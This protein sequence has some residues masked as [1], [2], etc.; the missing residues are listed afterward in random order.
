[1]AQGLLPPA[2]EEIDAAQGPQV[3]VGRHRIEP[4]RSV[5]LFLCAVEVGVVDKR[6]GKVGQH[7]G[8]VG[9]EVGRHRHVGE[10]QVEVPVEQGDAPE[11]TIGRAVI[12]VDRHGALGVELGLVEQRPV[13]AGAEHPLDHV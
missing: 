11:L 5:D 9:G 7:V 2:A 13:R 10:A 3:L 6:V 12:G 4:D 1:M 8:M